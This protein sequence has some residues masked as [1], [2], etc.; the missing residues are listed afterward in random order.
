M[1]Y[2]DA[3]HVDLGNLYARLPGLGRMYR[4]LGYLAIL[5]AVAKAHDPGAI[6]GL[7]VACVV[8]WLLA[9]KR[10]VGALWRGSL[11]AACLLCALILTWHK[12]GLPICTASTSPC[13]ERNQ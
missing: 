4:W 6:G 12:A 2:A 1:R 8:A 9:W 7:L 10:C 13:I 5:V 11:V 3:P